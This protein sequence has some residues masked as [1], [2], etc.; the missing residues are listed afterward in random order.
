MSRIRI[1]SW[2][3]GP[4]THLYWHGKQIPYQPWPGVLPA[5]AKNYP[6]PASASQVLAVSETHPVHRI[7]KGSSD[8][9]GPFLCVRHEYEEAA[10]PPRLYRED[11]SP[12]A[13][14][15]NYFG[16]FYADEEIVSD[17]TFPDIPLPNAAEMLALGATAIARVEPTNPLN[18]LLTTLGE[19]RSEGLPSIMGST[20]WRERTLR[21]RD[22]GGEYLNVEFGWRPLVNE[23]RS[24]CSTIKRADEL[25]REYERNAGK[26]VRASYEFPAEISSTRSVATG[27]Y[28]QPGLTAGFYSG[29]GTKTTVTTTR[30]RTW[31]EGTFT[32]HM[33]KGLGVGFAAKA[34]HLYGIRLT[35]ETLWNLTPW[36][37]ALDWFTNIGDNI[38]N[39]SA[40]A[41]E[42]LAMPY[43]YIM[44]EN[45]VT[46]RVTLTGVR[47]KSHGDLEALEQAYTTKVKA[48]LGATPFGFGLDPGELNGRQLAIIGALGLSQGS[49]N[50]TAFD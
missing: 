50:T 43:A 37:W 47:T 20:T 5:S 39:L 15:R 32:Y 29:S 17:S 9:G 41:F 30:K 40:F 12:T 42:G 10:A 25:I 34:N 46:K 49:S 31:F 14:S 33:P 22:A 13:A 19:L 8:L 21:A 28:P 35:P 45:S 7:G 18:S 2:R 44:R 6:Q 48:R 3:S 24:L 27:K 11:P 1:D 4:P 23:I 38:H 36:S 16:S 26:P